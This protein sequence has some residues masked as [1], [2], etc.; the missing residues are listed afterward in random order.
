MLVAYVV[1][2]LGAMK[3]IHFE[4]RE[5]MWRIIIPILALAAL[6]Y[7]LYKNLWPRPSHPY[8]LFPYIIGGCLAVGI[9]ITFAFPRLTRRIGRTSPRRRASPGRR[10]DG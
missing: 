1:A 10:A 3:F 7:T 9:A 5:P 6:V 8:N 4:H 2:N